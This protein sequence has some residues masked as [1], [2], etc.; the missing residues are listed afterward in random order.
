MTHAK[1]PAILRL[2]SHRE[3]SAYSKHLTRRLSTTSEFDPSAS[4]LSVSKLDISQVMFSLNTEKK[5]IQ[6]LNAQ[7]GLHEIS[8]LRA[9][10]CKYANSRSE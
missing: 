2:G 4:Y 10:P 8:D 3:D 7:K 9:D 5:I 1:D 6:I